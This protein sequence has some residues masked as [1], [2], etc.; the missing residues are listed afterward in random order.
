MQPKTIMA[1]YQLTL[2]LGF[3]KK[4]IELTVPST[5]QFRHAQILYSFKTQHLTIFGSIDGNNQDE[6]VLKLIIVQTEESIPISIVHLR[7][8]GT[9]VGDSSPVLHIWQD[10]R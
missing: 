9:V 2:N 7:Y 4:Q 6:K 8:L 3:P 1:R 5:F 10:C